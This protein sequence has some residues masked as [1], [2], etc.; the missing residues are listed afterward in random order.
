MS[1]KT[2]AARIQYLGGDQLSRI[3]KQKR[4]SLHYA[5]KNDYNS[6]MIKTPTHMAIPAIIKENHTEREYDKKNLSVDFDAG[7]KPGDTIEVIEDGTRWLIYLRYLTETAYLRTQIIRCRYNMEIDGQTYWFYF[8][9]P[10]EN[11]ISWYLK[12]GIN[13]NELNYKGTIFIKRDE[14]TLNFFKRFTKFRIEGHRWETQVVDRITVDGVLEVMVREY[15]DDLYEDLPE[16]HTVPCCEDV[17]LGLDEVRQ[18]TEVSY[19]VR[20]DYINP[21]F[22]WYVK[23]NPR[24]KVIKQTEMGDAC[25]VKVYDGAIRTFDI[26]YGDEK[27]TGFFQKVHINIDE[28]IIIGPDYL[29][30]YDTAVYKAEQPG[31]FSIPNETKAKITDQ[32][33]TSCKVEVLMS[34]KGSFDITFRPDDDSAVISRKIEVKSL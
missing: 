15:F 26:I 1:V 22:H 9:G 31:T 3:N 30:P 28:P 13:V 21:D 20:K 19:A 23:G 7:L 33:G 29:Y 14:H 10:L 18:D 24:V 5:L 25:T 27:H 11:D 32:D 12:K 16:I 17:I 34:R 8:Q 2:L 4:Q 6:R